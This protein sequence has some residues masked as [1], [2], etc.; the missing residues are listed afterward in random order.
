MSD[1]VVIARNPEPGSTLPYLLRI[2]HGERGPV[3]EARATWPRT[4]K[5][6]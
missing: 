2:P 4:A 1:D 3:L 6:Y 5:I